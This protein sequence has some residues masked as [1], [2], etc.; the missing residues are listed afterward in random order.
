M[1]IKRVFVAI[2]ISDEARRRVAARISYFRDDTQGSAIKWLHPGK[3]HL[4]LR[5]VGD[6]DN[7]QL[8]AVVSVAEKVSRH[9][10]KFKLCLKGA[11]L[12]PSPSKARILWIGIGDDHGT[13]VKIREMLEQEFLQLGFVGARKALTPHLTVARVKEP[14]MAGPL[15]QKHLNTEFEP[16]E[17]EASEI[18]IYESKLPPTGSVY[19]RVTGFELRSNN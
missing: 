15:I 13:C 18:V 5:F 19:S 12:F 1:R 10:S 3:L 7:E 8:K 2:D 9:F 4:T 17:F 6:V 16:V 14:R 11:G